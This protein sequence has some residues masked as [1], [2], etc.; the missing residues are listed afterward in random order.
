MSSC[1]PPSI[2]A[3]LAEWWGDGFYPA[4]FA[5]LANITNLAFGGNP[6]YQIADFFAFY[7][8]FGKYVQSILAAQ[9]NAGTPGSGYNIGDQISVIQPDAQNGILQVQGVTSGAPIAYIII[10]AGSGYSVSKGLTTAVIS[11][12]GTGALIDITAIS[13]FSGVIPQPVIQTYINLANASLQKAK[14]L[15]SWLLG[16]H[17]FIAHYVTLYLQ[18]EGNPG[19]TAGQVATSGLGKGIAVSKSA[20]DVSVGYETTI[21]K[22]WGAWNLTSYGQQLVTIAKVIGMGPMYVR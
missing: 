9:P 5:G 17:F 10:N 7:P 20:G 21:D 13:P 15:D 8:K 1:G 3:L 11:G 14:W 16:M 18:S 2:E 6:E 19:G 4:P 22:E 12:T